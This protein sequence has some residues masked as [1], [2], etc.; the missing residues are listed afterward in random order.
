MEKDLTTKKL[1][2]IFIDC[3]TAIALYFHHFFIILL[4]FY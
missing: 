4:C 2:S 3:Y 1:F